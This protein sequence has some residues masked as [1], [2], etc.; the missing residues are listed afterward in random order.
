M[1]FEGPGY[2]R[3]QGHLRFFRLIPQQEHDR[4]LW[5]VGNRFKF[6]DAAMGAMKLSRLHF[7][8]RGHQF[9]DEEERSAQAALLGGGSGR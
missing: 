2:G 4:M 7:W 8:Y 6:S 9:C 1:A 3:D 5:S